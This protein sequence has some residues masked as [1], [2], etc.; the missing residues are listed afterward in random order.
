MPE[1][2]PNQTDYF[3][4]VIPK[5]VDEIIHRHKLDID[6]NHM[7]HAEPRPV[8]EY[9]QLSHYL[10]SA[11]MIPSPHKSFKHFAKQM[12]IKGITYLIQH[13]DRRAD[14]FAEYAMAVQYMNDHR[15][16]KLTFDVEEYLTMIAGGRFVYGGEL[17]TSNCLHRP[18]ELNHQL[19]ST[20]ERKIHR[21]MTNIAHIPVN[22]RKLDAIF[23]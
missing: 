4:S 8:T 5:L 11:H 10:D 6:I 15:I 23:L 12:D 18:G 2:S 22:E 7:I 20:V 14:Y 9:I 19:T 17:Y 3:D 1:R 21:I 13:V 16:V